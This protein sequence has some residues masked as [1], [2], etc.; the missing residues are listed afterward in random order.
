MRGDD[1]RRVAAV[2]DDPVNARIAPD[3]LTERAQVVEGHEHRVER[4]HA[5][6]RAR[7]GVRRLTGE[8]DVERN[9]REHQRVELVRRPGME[10]ERG[11]DVTECPRCDQA[12]LPVSPLLRGRAHD[13]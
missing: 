10:H 8:L 11:V 7:G 4:V 2:G 12:R 9:H 3:H 13:A 1:V 6:I 5:E